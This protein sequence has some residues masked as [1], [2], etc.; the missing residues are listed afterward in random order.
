MLN[1]T[2]LPILEDNY[3]YI[4]RADDQIAIIDP[5]AAE[6]VIDYLEKHALTPDYIFNTH[7]HWDHVNG[8][9]K[10]KEKYGC[11]II[12]PKEGEDKIKGL[13][14]TKR[15][16][17]VFQFGNENVQVIKAAGHTNGHI[18]FYFQQSKIL[19]SGDALFSMGC[20]RLFEGTAEDMFAGFEHIKRL[21][22]DT[23]IY[24]GHE[25]TLGNAE[26]CLTI[27]PDNQDIMQRYKEVQDL[28]AQNRPTIPTTL[29]QERKT[30]V[31]LRAETAQELKRI[32][33]LK[34]NA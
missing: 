34:D 30:N 3:A 33:E 22:D 1:V 4:I 24:C 23:Q 8:N 12:G 32:R 10:I 26:F 16:D 18:C 21:P 15:H 2:I 7:H 20:G 27:E 28:R 31:F 6:P 13:D 9:L 19:F 14:I 25:Y 29:G 11:K 17:D 5:G